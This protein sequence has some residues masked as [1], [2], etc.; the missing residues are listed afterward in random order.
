MGQDIAWGTQVL[1]VWDTRV[2]LLN[3]DGWQPVTFRSC[4]T[5]ASLIT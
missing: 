5:L 4:A 3:Q 2:D 1:T